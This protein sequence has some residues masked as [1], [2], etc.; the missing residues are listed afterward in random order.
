MC[1]F[2]SFGA[3]FCHARPS[4]NVLKI[5]GACTMKRNITDIRGMNIQYANRSMR[6]ELG[7]LSKS[8]FQSPPCFFTIICMRQVILSWQHDGSRRVFVGYGV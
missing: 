3:R 5:G 7:V 6:L 1:G 8:T 4:D 2:I